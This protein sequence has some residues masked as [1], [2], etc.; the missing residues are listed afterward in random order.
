MSNKDIRNL[1][2]TDDMKEDAVISVFAKMIRCPELTVNKLNDEELI[3][4]YQYVSLEIG[5]R[6][7][8]GSPNSVKRTRIG[9]V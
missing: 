3:M 9:G 6:Y 8:S 4:L 5:M 7:N 1:N 2:L